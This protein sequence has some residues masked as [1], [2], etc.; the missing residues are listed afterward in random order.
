MALIVL[1][2]PSNLGFSQVLPKRPPQLR[3]ICRVRAK[4]RQDSSG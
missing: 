1:S 2:D 3:P 4:A